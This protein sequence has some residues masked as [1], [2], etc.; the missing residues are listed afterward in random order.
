MEEIR[1]T[2]EEHKAALNRVMKTDFDQEKSTIRFG[3]GQWLKK[4]VILILWI[5]TG[6]SRSCALHGFRVM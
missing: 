4:P 5:L 3:L 6:S 2:I 1:R